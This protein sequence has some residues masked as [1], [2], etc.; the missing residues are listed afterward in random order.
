MTWPKLILHRT[1]E[2][3]FAL[4]C[5][6]TPVVRN[7]LEEVLVSL[8]DEREISIFDETGKKKPR[9]N[10]IDWSDRIVLPPQR[11]FFGPF[12]N[13]SSLKKGK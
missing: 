8:R 6:D 2:D 3:V 11:T 4:R 10:K 7:L 12:A 9:A 1:L 5:N 13:Y